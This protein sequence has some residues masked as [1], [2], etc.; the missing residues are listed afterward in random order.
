M[1][2]YT[3]Q[4]FKGFLKGVNAAVDRY[5]QPQGSIPRSSNLLLTKRGSLITCDGSQIIF[6]FNGAPTAGR[7]KI[8]TTFLFSPT[9]VPAYYLMLAQALDLQL[10]KPFNLVLT[11]GGA[12]GN[13]TGNV[14]YKVT[15]LDG[16]GGETIAS[17]ESTINVAANHKV[18]L[19]WNIVPN[20]S[21][22]NIYRSF[23]TNSEVQVSSATLPV[24][25]PALGTLTATYTDDGIA[26]IP[27]SLA[28]L[29]A[30]VSPDGTQVTWTTTTPHN[31]F[32]GYTIACA[33]AGVPA[34]SGNYLIQ[35]TP[36][37]T[38]FVT[39]NHLN[40]AA[41]TVSGGG[42]I[43]ALAPPAADNTQQIVLFKMPVLPAAKVALPISYN[44]SNIVALFPANLRSLSS[45]SSGGGGT[46]G[47]GTGGGLGPGGSA[48][49]GGGTVGHGLGGPNRNVF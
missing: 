22:Y 35:S 18:T 13:F 4:Q 27:I 38:M 14:F 45:P 3:S 37:S 7:G 26:T 6:A 10:G 12:G 2:E 49:S 48:P 5:N 42:N 25:Q 31:L 33:A 30:V 47:A 8:L 28:I 39:D 46:G 9:G 34:L 11:D 19:T 43:T 16:V 40:V 20:A 23:V 29:T 15:A 24:A 1:S 44:N 32:A 17:T 41:Y 21:Y 36:T